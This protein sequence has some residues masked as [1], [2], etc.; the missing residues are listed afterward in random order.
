MEFC[1]KEQKYRRQ[2][3]KVI[4]LDIDGVLTT[5]SYNNPDT[6]HI[7]PEKVQILS[8]TV[9]RTGA[10]I[11]LIS[12]W[13]M[14]Y[15]KDSGKKEDYYKVLENIL[16][17]YGLEIFDITDDIPEKIKEPLPQTFTLEDLDN[18]E[19]V[20]GTGRAAEVEKWIRDH[21][22]EDFVILD[23]ENHDWKEYGMNKNWIHTSYYGPDCEAGLLDEHIDK[24]CDI[25]DRKISYKNQPGF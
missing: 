6:N 7:N 23:D 24:I 22:V 19:G 18:V 21:S 3:M 25:L 12:T 16:A 15:D 13:K 9:E 17:Q 2:K 1:L 20:H 10:K 14:G 4:F 8:Q 11:V 5:C